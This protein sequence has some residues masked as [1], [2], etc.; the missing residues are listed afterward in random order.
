MSVTTP[1]TQ[2]TRLQNS[3]WIKGKALNSVHLQH[4]LLCLQLSILDYSDIFL[5]KA[6]RR[7]HCRVQNC[8]SWPI[9][10]LTDSDD[11]ETWLELQFNVC[12]SDPIP[13]IWHQSSS[14]MKGNPFC[15]PAAPTT[16]FVS[17]WVLSII[18]TYFW[19]RALQRGHYRLQKSVMNSVH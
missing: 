11:L 2:I 12:C 13:P 4:L 10:L 5:M 7:G 17:S 1:I 6:F 16:Y 15:A 14:W 9:F 18:L 8:V 19:G 3:S